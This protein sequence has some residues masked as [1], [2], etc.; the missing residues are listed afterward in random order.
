MR[1]GSS[2]KT[3]KAGRLPP[4][5][6]QELPCV[7]VGHWPGFYFNGD[8][9]GFDVLKTVKAR[10]DEYD[11]DGT[12]TLWMK[13]SEIAHYWMAREFTDITVVEEKKQINIVTQFPT[14]NFTLAID[15]PIRNIQGNGWHL[16]EVHSRRDFQKDT[17][18]CEGKQTF[19][20]IDLEIGETNLFVTETEI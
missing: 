15:A 7:L 17:F 20:A 14:A 9:Y 6:D 19:V 5:L 12:K 4:I 11:P 10:L 18:I 16:R 8:K 1:I 2:R 3:D 13:T